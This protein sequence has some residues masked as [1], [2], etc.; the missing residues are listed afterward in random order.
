M[1]QFKEWNTE[2][3]LNEKD[4]FI[5]YFKTPNNE[6]ALRLAQKDKVIAE[7][8]LKRYKDNPFAN[9][10]TFNKK[11]LKSAKER[12]KKELEKLNNLNTL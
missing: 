10:I 7:Q 2:I 4:F 3:Y 6:L 9:A 12:I 8:Y 11:K 1:E 5:A